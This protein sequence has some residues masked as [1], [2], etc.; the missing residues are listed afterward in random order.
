MDGLEEDRRGT[1][2]V[3]NG[4]IPNI[5]VLD[6]Q[7]EENTR[8]ATWIKELLD[9]EVPLSEIGIFV[10]T[11]DVLP[12]VRSVATSLNLPVQTLN[13][14]LTLKKNAIAIGTMHLAKGLEFRCV[15]VMACDDDLL[16]LESRVES[17]VSE[18]DLDEV[19]ATERHLLYVACTRARERLLVTGV[20]P[21]SDFLADLNL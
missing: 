9:E 10:R 7:S 11:I 19:Y 5:H 14:S 2:S 6:S 1:V 17:I 4:P 20:Q 21:E 18:E 3:F 15:A 8:V 16:P 13:E 12:R